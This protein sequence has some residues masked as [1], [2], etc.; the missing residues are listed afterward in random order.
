MATT[1]QTETRSRPGLP[2]DSARKPPRRRAGPPK[3]LLT[4]H[5]VSAVAFLG[6]VAGCSSPGIR[7]A[8]RDDIAEAHTIYELMTVLPFALGIPLSFLALGS[9]ILLA[10]TSTWGLFRHWWVTAKLVLLVVTIFVG[11]LV[12]GPAMSDPANHTSATGDGDRSDEWAVVLVLGLQIAM[13]L[14]ASVLA[15]LKPGGRIPWRARSSWSMTAVT[16]RDGLSRRVRVYRAFPRLGLTL[17]PSRIGP[18]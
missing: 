14:T 18:C 12:T 3:G 17:V 5:I 13:I 6:S 15:V 10:L 9:G 11:A 8:T 2:P 4:L 7:A 1:T 16:A